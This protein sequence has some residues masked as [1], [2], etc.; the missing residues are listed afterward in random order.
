MYDLS[1]TDQWYLTGIDD[2]IKLARANAED[3]Q[4]VFCPCKDCKN[5]RKWGD[6]EHIRLHLIT[7]GFMRD[8]TIWTL[9]GEVGQNVAQENNDDVPMPNVSLNAF[10]PI[11][12]Y[13]CYIVPVPT[14]DNV[15]RNTFV[16]DT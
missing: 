7:R 11:D 8:Y 1:S 3:S 6:V 9:H 15:F 16:D 14:N 10:L 13:Q 2:F 12:D 4:P 5:T